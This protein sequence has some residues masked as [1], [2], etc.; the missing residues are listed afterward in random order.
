MQ[1]ALEKRKLS[2]SQK[3]EIVITYQKLVRKIALGYARRST[4]PAEDLI[5]V[6]LIGLLEAAENFKEFHKTLFQTYAVHYISGHIRHYLRDKQNLM[7]GPRA[8]QELSYKMSQ[9]IKE[10]TQELGR[11]PNNDELSK[12]LEVTSNRIDEVKT[13]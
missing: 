9:T 2:K 8:L 10:L 13:Y 12:E 6:G 1:A 5:Q 4:D 7:K 11:E 3:N